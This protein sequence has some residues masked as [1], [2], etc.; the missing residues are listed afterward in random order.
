MIESF[1]QDQETLITQL[2]DQITQ[3]LE[4]NIVQHGQAS[5]AVSGG[6]TP[7]PLFRELARRDLPWQKVVI[8]LVDERWVA[9]SDPASNEYLVHQYLLQDQAAAASF[10]G[11]KNFFPTAVQGESECELRLGKIP[12]PFTVLILGMGND[13]HTASL[14]P[15][16]PQ[17]AAA[18]DMNSGKS[19]MAVTPVDV[20][21][22]R[23]TLTLPVLLDSQQI[24]LHITGR[25][26]KAVLEQ[27]QAEGPATEMPVRFVLRQQERPVAVYWAA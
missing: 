19:C 4:K 5:L 7:K 18:T 20:P 25:A 2:A 27:A 3:A 9:P 21:H 24:I 17:L 6:S 11:L 26:K 14:F 16:S 12:R 1:F 13:G 8:T 22:E 15:G 10:V 23:M